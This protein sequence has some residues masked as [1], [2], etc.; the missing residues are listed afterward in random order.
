MIHAEWDTATDCE[1]E[2]IT[3]DE[4]IETLGADEVTTAPYVLVLGGAGGG[5]LAVEGTA[6]ELRAFARRILSAVDDPTVSD[7]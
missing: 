7:R 1:V 5:C 2:V 3:A 6:A 4:A